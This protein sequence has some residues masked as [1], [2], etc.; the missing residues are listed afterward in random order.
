MASG[1]LNENYVK[2]NIKK[3]KFS[4]GHKSLNIKKLKWKKWK[5]MKKFNNNNVNMSSPSSCFKCGQ[6]GHWARNC[7][8]STSKFISYT[9]VYLSN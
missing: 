2:V 5:D 4:R 8:V 1:T 7:K 3:K 6:A 9:Y